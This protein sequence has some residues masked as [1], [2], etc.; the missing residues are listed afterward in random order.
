MR[1]TSNPRE[2]R[3]ASNPR[4]YRGAWNPRKYRGA[5]FFPLLFCLFASAL[6]GAQSESAEIP[7]REV[8]I[9][10]A[11]P[12][13]SAS[14]SLDWEAGALGLEIVRALD[15]ATD[16]LP[17]AKSDAES[18]IESR[19]GAFL[20]A[21]VSPVLVDSSHTFGELLGADALLFSQISGLA[22][23]ARREALFLRK[24]FSALVARYSF[25]LFGEGGITV[26][27]IP[28]AESPLRRRLGYVATRKFTGLVIYAGEKVPSV[29]TGVELLPRPALFPRIYDEDMNL[30]LEKGMCTPEALARWGIV[31][32]ASGLDSS[33]LLRAG[34]SPLRLAARAVFGDNSTDLV[35]SNE[36]AKQM[37]TMPENIAFLKEGRIVIIYGGLREPAP[38]R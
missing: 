9:L 24:D 8:R 23:D 7:R 14:S 20:I 15:P 21:A 29:G 19:L 2:Y 22:N 4:E 1:R 33:A 27:L 31:G 26:S 3:G 12:G 37:L 5:L 36:G 34:L 38:N 28:S 10:P 18:D 11:P 16:A 25:P 13:F 35:I 6:A 17:R 30:V 32:Y